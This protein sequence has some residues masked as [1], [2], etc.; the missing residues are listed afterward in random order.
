LLLRWSKV[1]NQFVLQFTHQFKCGTFRFGLTLLRCSNFSNLLFCSRYSHGFFLDCSSVFQSVNIF[2]RQLSETDIL[3][4][5]GLALDLSHDFFRFVNLLFLGFCRGNFFLW[6]IESRLCQHRVSQERVF[7]RG[8][9]I[10]FEESIPDRPERRIL[11]F[12]DFRFWLGFL[13]FHFWLSRISTIYLS[14]H[15]FFQTSRLHL[16]FGLRFL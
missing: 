11:D 5:C 15:V 4:C 10:I 12:C 13:R 7:T 8:L 16:R 14:K 2:I 3:L 6:F 1:G 9:F